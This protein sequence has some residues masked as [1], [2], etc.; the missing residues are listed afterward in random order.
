[1]VVR[2]RVTIGLVAVVVM[3]VMI[4]S[5]LGALIPGPVADRFVVGLPMSDSAVAP[6]ASRFVSL[7]PARV[8][9]TRVLR[10]TLAAGSAMSLPIV[11]VGG[12]PTD[13]VA[14]AV[15]ITMVNSRSAGYVTASPSGR[16]RPAV[17]NVNAEQ[18]G[19]TVATAAVVGIGAAGSIDVFSSVE[20]DLI[21]DL[22]GV[23][24]PAVSAT[25]GRFVPVAPSRVFDSRNRGRLDDGS[26][27]EI[28]LRSV[29]P[30][31]SAVVLNLTA[32]DAESAGYV[33]VRPAE[34]D[35]S[36]VSNLNIAGPQNTVANV[37]IVP[38]GSNGAVSAS[39]FR[40]MHLIVD[41]AGYFTGP[42]APLGT[43]GLFVPLT[44]TRAFDSRTNSAQL[45]LRAG[46]PRTLALGASGVVPSTGVGAVLATV[47]ATN[48]VLPGFVTVY[49]SSS[50]T[51][52]T[53]N[54]NID[55]TWQTVANLAVTAVG[56]GSNIVLRSDRGTE[57]LVDV[58]GYFTGSPFPPSNPPP[59]PGLY[60]PPAE[61]ATNGMLKA[62]PTVTGSISPKSVVATGTGLV[63]AQNMMYQHTVTVYDRNGALLSTI[64]DS[65]GDQR[66]APV[67]MAM[68]VDGLHA[69]VS[70]Y[71]MYGPGTGPEGFDTCSPSSAV[72]DSTVFRIDLTTF[73]IDQVID[74]GR[75]P[76]FLA[77]SPD[78]RLLIVSN[79]CGDDLSI[80]DIATAK[81]IRRVRVGR[82]PRG[83]ALSANSR[84]AYV[85]LMGAGQV[86][87]VD[88]E[89]GA[90]VDRFAVGGGARHLNLAPDG[91]HLYVTLNE[92]RSV[93][94]VDL[95]TKS[96]VG[97]AVTG[98]NPRTAA[99]SVDG[100][101]L[102][103]VNYSS[104]TASK[105]RTSD[106]VVQQTMQTATNP[107]GVTYDDEARQLWV[108]CYV[109]EIRR[110]LNETIAVEIT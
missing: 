46:P 62:L 37:A 84:L 50:R 38:V 71:S 63:L 15:N 95:A 60:D 80:I 12:V 56:P 59:V 86:A 105:V 110:F 91:K 14:V 20:T 96:I 7:T 51:P 74:V 4:A 42:S 77:T 8:F 107:I 47:T 26:Q 65:V 68:A 33:T 13:A 34:A 31:A 99:L 53:S 44:P 5:A 104:N 58:S 49:P 40:S 10:K 90:V 18:V 32:T 3:V 43:E 85:A 30:G 103:V 78:G 2:Q 101:A 19:Q 52:E 94:K 100:T 25:S 16:P 23:W 21:V 82:Y 70:N 69:Y 48:A 72:G 108:S 102:F 6:S 89:S 57:I 45:R 41:I 79:W 67:E 54:L 9:D 81:E 11:G 76:K 66:G 109:G 24:I 22:S 17:S 61:P 97:R 73:G 55:H 35:R 28:D 64:R 83:L 93:V 27:V 92:E 1:M 98:D 106:M 36:A 75:V 88:V 39:V 87:V 29:A